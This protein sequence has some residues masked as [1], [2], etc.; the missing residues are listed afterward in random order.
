M[1]RNI[2]LIVFSFLV[3]GQVYSQELY[4]GVVMSNASV[5]V[6]GHA[7]AINQYLSF[8]TAMNI[9]GIIGY[10]IDD[11]LSVEGM[12][13]TTVDGG[14]VNP[15]STVNDDV[16]KMTQLSAYGV[17]KGNGKTHVRFKFGLTNSSLDYP[18]YVVGENWAPEDSSVSVLYGI[19][20]GFETSSGKEFVLEWGQV[21]K[22]VAV[23]NFGIIF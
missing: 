11:N 7:S 21:S 2:L 4:Y 12:I 18:S 9:G 8:E 5:D 10:K 13:S 1:K 20:L 15:F 6:K 14:D 3:S 19:G 22:D 17:Y 16:W 23:I